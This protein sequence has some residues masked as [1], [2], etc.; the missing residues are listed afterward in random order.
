MDTSRDLRQGSTLLNQAPSSQGQSSADGNLTSKAAMTG[1][2]WAIAAAAVLDV[3]GTGIQNKD[4]KRFLTAQ[5][6]QNLN[7]QR[8]NSFQNLLR[9]AQM[10]RN[11]ASG[12]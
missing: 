5:A 2:P 7:T 9:A 12:R 1:N 11:P 10:M 3:I 6:D 8:A 4:Q